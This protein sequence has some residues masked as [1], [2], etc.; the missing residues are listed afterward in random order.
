MSVPAIALD[1]REPRGIII[2]SGARA[3]RRLPFRA[4]L[5]SD[6]S[7]DGACAGQ[8]LG[9]RLESSSGPDGSS[10]ECRASP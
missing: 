9:S 7:D 6:G 10:S 4:Y 8:P 2:R 3:A 5:W 1:E